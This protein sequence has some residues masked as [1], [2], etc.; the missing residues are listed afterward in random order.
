MKSLGCL[1]VV[2]IL[3]GPAV[4]AF[5]VFYS[6]SLGYG[7]PAPDGPPPTASQAFHDRVSDVLMVGGLVVHFA[8]WILG[9]VAVVR[10]W[11]QQR[12]A[13]MKGFEVIQ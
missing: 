10:A 6:L 1:S 2:L 9:L 11:H 13:A 3:G 4:T 12:N 8:G 5:G 7:L